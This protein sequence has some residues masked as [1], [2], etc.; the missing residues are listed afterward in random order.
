[1][2]ACIDAFDWSATPVGPVERWPPHLRTAVDICLGS[3]FPSF[4]WWGPQLTQLYNDGAVGILRA[5]HPAALGAPARAVWS[6]AWTVV[7]DLVERVLASGET[8]SGDDL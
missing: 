5:K 4:V 1:M 6:D 8:V 2:R 7:G 3:A